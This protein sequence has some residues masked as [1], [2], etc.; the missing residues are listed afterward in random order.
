MAGR[1]V[2]HDIGMIEHRRCKGASNVTNTTILSG[3]DMAEVLLGH[4]SRSTITMTFYAVIDP[5]GMI[6]N[7]VS[8]GATGVMAG[9]TILGSVLMNCRIR[10]PSDVY[11]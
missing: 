1:T 2:I 8:E 10:R 9:G 6:K 5:A 3:K 7:T 4:R 11:G